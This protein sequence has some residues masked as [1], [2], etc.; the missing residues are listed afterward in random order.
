MASSRIAELS[1]IIARGTRDI[2]EHLEAEGLPS[3]SF[4]ANS[5]PRSLLDS[6]IV[7]S[8]QAILEATDELHALMLGPIGT[9]TA[10]P[11]RIVSTDDLQIAS[12]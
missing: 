9:F 4:D 8:R 2:D 1:E 12:P 11:V 7:A 10:L 3:P 5:P 6:R